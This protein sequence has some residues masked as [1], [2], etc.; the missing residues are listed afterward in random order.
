MIVGAGSVGSRR[1]RLLAEMG[2]EVM[3][4]DT[5]EA[6]AD[7]LACAIG[8][9]IVPCLYMAGWSATFVCTPAATHLP[10]A[11][12]V[13]K[14]GCKGVFIEK[15]LSTSLLAVRNVVEECERRG[16]VTMGACNMRWAY[17]SN[18]HTGYHTSIETS[19]PLSGWRVGAPEAYAGN[20]IV[21][22]AAIHDLDLAVWLNGP[23]GAM[24]AP[25]PAVW[26]YGDDHVRLHLTHTGRAETTIVADWRESAPTVRELVTT[27]TKGV[28]RC[29][30][31]DCGDDMYRQEMQHFLD[32]V[33][34]WTPTSNPIAN[35]AETL[36]W[37]LKARDLT[38]KVAA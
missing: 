2:H 28:R 4:Y 27:A 9:P 13:I 11:A 15:P 22:E 16:V 7:K 38:R 34:S 21:M 18:I 31:P 12:E 24:S 23:I 29:Y 36:R 5:D 6:R 3:I 10:V 20:G 33:A 32:H 19:R 17:G 14:A 30:R 8:V 1:A 35:A 37:A 25:D 26:R